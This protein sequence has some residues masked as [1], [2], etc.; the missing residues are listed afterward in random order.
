M[1]P[2][3]RRKRHPAPPRVLIAS[4]GHPEITKGGAENAAFHLFEG[5]RERDTEAWFLGCGAPAGQGAELCITQ[6]FSARE[7]LYAPGA[8]NWFNFANRD[9]RMPRELERLL[10]E[11][12]P[13]IVHFHHYAGLGVEAFDIVRR[14]LPNAAIVLTLHEFLAICHHFGQMVTRPDLHLCRRATETRCA[15]CFPEIAPGDFF[16]RRRYIQGFLDRVDQFIAPSAFLAER[17]VQ[18]GVPEA[19][20]AVVEN[21]LPEATVAPPVRPAGHTL[22][23]GFFGQISRLKGIEILL[24]AAGALAAEGHNSISF[25]VFGDYRSQ[26]EVFRLDVAKRLATPGSNVSFHGPY[27]HTEVDALMG[28]VDAVLVPSIWWENAPLVIEEALRNRRPVLCSDIGGMAEKVRDGIDG[29]HFRMGSAH[30]LADLLRR[31][32]ADRGL[33]S[34]VSA[35]MRAPTPPAPTLDAHLDLYRR[36]LTENPGVYSRLA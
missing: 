5:L 14:V 16:L 15:A 34:T 13:D 2:E 29:F 4:H 26:P 31:L 19:R 17:Y 18:W 33:L 23:V 3:R 10:V 30:A 25:A 21:V 32:D 35:T 24:D 12:A 7:F 6:P 28:G 36:L 11:L 1:P 27:D 9:P 20:M 8:F 22:L